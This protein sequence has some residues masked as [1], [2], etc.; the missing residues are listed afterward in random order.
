M[1]DITLTLKECTA[2]QNYTSFQEK[3]A[4]EEAKKLQENK[5]SKISFLNHEQYCK[6]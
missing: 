4:S 6:V 3:G 2:S 1:I 5:K